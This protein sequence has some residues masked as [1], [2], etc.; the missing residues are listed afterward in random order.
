MED[1]PCGPRKHPINIYLHDQNYEVLGRALLFL[2][3]ICETS[4]SKRERMELFLDLYGNS[5]IRDKTDN[6]L[7][8]VVNELIQLVTEDDRCQSVLKDMVSFDDLKYKQRDELEDVISSYH[9]AHKFDIEKYRDDRAR[10]H[11]KERYDVRR[12]VIDWDYSF[13]VVN[14]CKYINKREYM[15]W[16]LRGIAWETRLASQ[17]IPNRT[18]SSYVPG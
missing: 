1:V 3:L 8:G 18:F 13:S 9:S 17:T 5:L 4:I 7:Q 16:R 14:I 2:T 12:N 10:F 11:Y 6:Y 15:A